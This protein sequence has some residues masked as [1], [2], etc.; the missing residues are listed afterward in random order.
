[1]TTNND[2][3]WA[4]DATT[5]KVKWRWSPNDVAVFSDFGQV[6]NRGVALCDGHVFVLTL[7]MQIVSLESGDRRAP[8]RGADLG[9]RAQRGG[10][11]WLLG[12]QRADLRRPPSDLRRGGLR[13]RRARL[14]GGVQHDNLTPA[15]PNPFWNIPPEGTE[16]RQYD[17]LAGGGVAWTPVTVD[18]DN[19]HALLRHRLRHAALFPSVRPGSDPRADSVIAVNLKTGRMGWWQQ[20]MAFNEW[21]YDTAQPPLVYTATINGKSERVVSVA[22]MEGLW[23]AYNAKT[24]R[25]IYQQV[26]LLDHTEHPTLAGQAG[27]VYP[28][29]SA[30]STTPRRRI[31][32]QTGYV[33]KA[34]AETAA[35]E[36]AGDPH[37][38]AEEGQVHARR[39]VPRAGERQL[40]RDAAGMAGLRIDRRGQPGAG[41]EVW[42][43]KTPQP[44]RGGVTT[45]ASGLGFDGG[46]DGVLRVF[47]V[48]TG[49][50]LWTFQTGHQIAAGTSI[51]SVNGKEYVAITVGGT[52]TSSNGGQ[53]SQLQVFALGGSSQ[54][55]STPTDLT[56]RLPATGAAAS[57][58][59][60]RAASHHTTAHRAVA[61]Q[62]VGKI[63]TARAVAVVSWQP[64]SSNVQAVSGRLDVERQAGGRRRRQ[65][66]QLRGSPGD[67][68]AGA[69]LLRHRRHRRRKPRRPRHRCGP[70]ERRRQA[71]QRRT[72]AGGLLGDRR[73]RE[74]VRDQR[75]ARL[76]RAQRGRARLRQ[77][78]IGGPRRAAGGPSAHLRA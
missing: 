57:A 13:V 25:P 24:G 55:S 4:L 34:A 5:G 33:Y 12:D 51:Y 30:G 41:A 49:K 47:D 29:R 60:R 59:P 46:G 73:L 52:V 74:R 27:D 18:P 43:D 39:R 21:S 32:P 31:D 26:K 68:Q 77:R 78:D 54:Q 38:G 70:G 3:V 19:R 64:N 16:W 42:K 65:R 6:A 53:A 10:G 58:P 62:G 22:T 61:A 63:V 48:K 50:V 9:R 44:E 40:R 56:V 35:V 15:W 8:A 72:E 7:N 36:V 23:F 17:A 75:G 66:R 69:L 71:A 76:R 11:L 67:R 1:M 20:Q 45:T 28:P 37:A 2:N 14:R